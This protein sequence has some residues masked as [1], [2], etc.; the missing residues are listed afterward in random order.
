MKKFARSGRLAPAVAAMLTVA[1]SLGAASAA[2]AGVSVS[3]QFLAGTIGFNSVD[4]PVYVLAASVN[5]TGFTDDSNLDNYIRLDTEAFD[6]DFYPARGTG[7]GTTGSG[8]YAGVADLNA[9]IN[10][11]TPTTL[12]LYD[13]VTGETSIYSFTLHTPGF[14]DDHI[15]PVH[16]D[17]LVE[18]SVISDSPTFMFSQP[19]AIDPLNANTD[20]FVGLLA[21]NPANGV[22]SPGVNLGDTSWTPTGPLAPDN[23]IFLVITQNLLIDQSLVEF[24][25]PVLTSGPDVLENNTS[26]LFIQTSDQRE[27]LRVVPA[28]GAGAAF[29][30]AGLM[31]TRRR[32]R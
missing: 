10:S 9:A 24:G 31:A 30:A 12:K 28:P 7:S 5:A 15:R 3:V 25:S 19:A 21:G 6:A 14:T 23:Y 29:V 20:L 4:P 32:R 22:F 11:A 1:G 16:I 26:S 17:G 27:G 2:R 18:N 13:G 8:G